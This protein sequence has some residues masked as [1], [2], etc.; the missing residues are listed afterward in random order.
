MLDSGVQQ[1]LSE[2]GIT[3]REFLKFC[4]LMTAVLALPRSF[5]SHIAR[6][7]QAQARTPMKAFSRAAHFQ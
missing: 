2:R 3:R 1:T 7:M 4:S 6:S 5:S